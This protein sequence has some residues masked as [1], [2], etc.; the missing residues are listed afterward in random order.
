MD[1]WMDE[2]EDTHNFT[3]L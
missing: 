2:H 1:E 3:K